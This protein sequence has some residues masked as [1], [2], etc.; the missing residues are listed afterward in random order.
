MADTKELS[1]ESRIESVDEAAK[2]AA[3]FAKQARL[4]EEAL[5]AIDLA[6]RESVA[7]AVKHGNKFDEAK[8]V[9][10]TFSSDERGLEIVV[11]DFGTG[12]LVDDVPDPTDPDNLLKA[13][14]RGILFMNTFMDEVEWQ[15][16]PD[17]GLI[18]K[19]LKKR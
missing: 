15:T 13:N 16:A 9:E 1:L 17:G 6:V 12:F 8:Q 18:V 11:R 3:K 14:G 4:G 10:I 19:M 5:F 2:A 7:N